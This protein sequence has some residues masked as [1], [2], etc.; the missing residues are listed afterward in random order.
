MAL[1]KA[2][3]HDL[4][5]ELEALPSNMVGEIIYGALHAHPRPARKHGFAS[6]DLL[7]ELH[8]PFRRGRNGP[9]GWIFIAE[10]ELALLSRRPLLPRPA[11]VQRQVG[12]PL[13]RL[14]LTANESAC[15]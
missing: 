6:S 12:E 3:Q 9:G 10:Q 14:P 15:Q 7:A 13:L 1:A 4:Y 8:S 2:H 5:A 11:I